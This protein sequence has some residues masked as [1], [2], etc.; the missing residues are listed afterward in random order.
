ME[1][2]KFHNDSNGFH[3]T[4]EYK[5]KPNEEILLKMPTVSPNKR[6][7]NDIGWQC[8]GDI[9]L[10]ATLSRKPQSDDAIWTK[11]EDYDEVN[12]T[13]SYI[14]IKCGNKES[15]VAIRALLN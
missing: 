8:D 3:Y 7:V 11:I 10:Y 4:F 1:I 2:H 13:I 6:G 5:M 9:T 15:R 12:K 14:K